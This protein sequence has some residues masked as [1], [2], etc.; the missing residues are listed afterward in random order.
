MHVA[1]HCVRV[2]RRGTRVA[3]LATLALHLGAAAACAQT[4]S[5]AFV[6]AGYAV[7]QTPQATVSVRYTA[8]QTAGNL[9]VVVIGFNDAVSHV[10]AVSD[11]LGNGY[12]VAVG[13][14]V[15]SGIQ[16]QVIYF[17]ANIAAAAANANLVTVT[18]DQPVDF[19][20]VRIAE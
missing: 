14:T 16:T 13:P 17:A 19:P 18:F 1:I 2:A 20:D 4:G 7:P 5:I 15:Q 9:N 10:A 12:A 11:S 6:Q 3:W 8:A